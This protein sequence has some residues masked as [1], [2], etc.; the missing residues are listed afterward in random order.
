MN[1]KGQFSEFD[2]EKFENLKFPKKSSKYLPVIT[3]MKFSKID[4]I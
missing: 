1:K 2:F 3:E 4:W